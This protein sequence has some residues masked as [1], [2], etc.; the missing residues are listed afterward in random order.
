MFKLAID[1]GH[2]LHTSGKRCLKSLDPNETREWQLNSRIATKVQNKLHGYPIE[3]LRM[4]DTTGK[5]DVALTTRCNKA[6]A[7]GADFYLSIHHNAGLVGRAGGGTEVY[8]Y[9]GGCG[10]T[11][12]A[13]QKQIYND[14]CNI[15]PL[16]TKRSNGG[17][18]QAD[19][20]VLRQ[21]RM[22]AV[23]IECGFMDSPT[24]VP[25]ILTDAWADKAADALV[26]SI[27]KMTNLQQNNSQPNNTAP[28]TSSSQI[29][30]IYQVWDDV[31][32]AWL[33][34]V[35]NNTDYAGIFGH[36]ICAVYAN[37][38]RGDISYRVRVCGGTWLPEVVNRSDYAGIF[39]K[40]ID[41]IAIKTN[42]GATI[43]YQV[44]L[45]GGEWLSS[46]TGCDIN[47]AYNGYAGL[48]GKPID[49]LRIWLDKDSKAEEEAKKRAEEEARLKAEE[50]IKRKAEEE[51]KRKAEEA[52]LKAEEEAR[53]KAEEEAR[54]KAEEEAKKKAEEEARL[55][56]EEEAKKQAE[57]EAKKKAEE[58]AKKKA[59][60]QNNINN[61]D[62]SDLTKSQKDNI[63]K[64]LF[65]FIK[66]II[67]AIFT[68]G[69]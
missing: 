20:A 8:V 54:L 22:P 44:H 16:P 2:G 14:F 67:N 31:R 27:L 15:A 62:P 47:D 7:W 46:V 50:E 34:N 11:S 36:D 55:K 32:N 66:S 63:I 52:R 1:A 41:A 60:I 13:W 49:G 37:L 45:R 19:F 30:V 4:D 56:A 51:A 57:E 29:D 26:T 43:H 25:L 21:T 3:T 18:K 39:N 5:S 59:E 40:P 58:E 68:K 35:V 28:S 65:D 33:P 38:S 10:Q 17:A 6:N 12:L 23:L 69:E 64:L 9:N 24:D 42:T 53:L 61:L 48:T